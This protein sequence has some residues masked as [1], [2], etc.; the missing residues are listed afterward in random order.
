MRLMLSE[1][2]EAAKKYLDQ[3]GDMPVNLDYELDYEFEYNAVDLRVEIDVK[4]KKYNF[5]IADYIY[6]CPL[7]LVKN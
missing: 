2:A 6:E 7:R 5:T 3:Y 1:L 4:T